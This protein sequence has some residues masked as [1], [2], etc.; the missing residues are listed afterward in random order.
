MDDS[1]GM[2]SGE[3]VSRKGSS[4]GVHKSNLEI[5]G[6]PG[7][8]QRVYGIA[9]AMAN[10]VRTMGREEWSGE[11]QISNFKMRSRLRRPEVV[12]NGG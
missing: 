6:P 12:G 9:R 10:G 8:L 3:R 7:G 1:E 5:W 2:R 11:A 4:R